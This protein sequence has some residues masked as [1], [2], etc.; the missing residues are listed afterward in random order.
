MLS[1]WDTVIFAAVPLL[2]EYNCVLV[3]VTMPAASFAVVTALSAILAVATDVKNPEL[4]VSSEVLV[5][6]VILA[7]AFVDWLA[8]NVCTSAPFCWMVSVASLTVG[9]VGLSLKSF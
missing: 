5:G 2:F 9:I 6:T 7:V 8:V 3:I 1:A 4:F